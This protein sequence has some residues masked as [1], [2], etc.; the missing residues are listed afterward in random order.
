[1]GLATILTPA[2]AQ[3]RPHVDV[4][5]ARRQGDGNVSEVTI[6]KQIKLSNAHDYTF[7]AEC[8]A[9]RYPLACEIKLAVSSSMAALRAASSTSA[10]TS[11][12]IAVKV[13]NHY[14]DEVLKV[15][16]V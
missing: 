14:G 15:F 9:M 4:G 2:N 12:G 10:R 13:I 6:A 7:S 8:R 5:R 11:C 1:L 16:G 3:K